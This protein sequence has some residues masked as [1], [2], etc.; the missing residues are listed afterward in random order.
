MIWS[1]DFMTTYFLWPR[2]FTALLACG[3]FAVGLAS[4]EAQVT[5]DHRPKEQPRQFT[6]HRKNPPP[7]GWGQT[8]NPHHNPGN[9]GGVSV[10]NTR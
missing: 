8:Q 1:R 2:G 3:A 7:P 9:Q 4:A 5:R 6:D 10:K